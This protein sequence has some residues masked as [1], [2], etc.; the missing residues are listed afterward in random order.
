M[1]GAGDW[2][3]LNFLPTSKKL[4]CLLIAAFAR[5]QNAQWNTALAERVY[6]IY[7]FLQAILFSLF[8]R[9]FTFLN[10]IEALSHTL[11]WSR[12]LP[13][14][15]AP[16]QFPFKVQTLFSRIF[17]RPVRK[18]WSEGDRVGGNC[19]LLFSDSCV[20]FLQGSPSEV[21]I[22]SERPTTLLFARVIQRLSGRSQ[23]NFPFVRSLQVM[24]SFVC[25]A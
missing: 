20:L 11:S 19:R 13:R 6:G 1:R 7:V 21:W 14:V 10:I 18:C 22:C 17:A 5:E 2:R 23:L 12:I 25:S 16:L 24:L 4:C 3:G 8:Q 15:G 9:I